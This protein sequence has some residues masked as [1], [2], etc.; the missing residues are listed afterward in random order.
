MGLKVVPQ[1][2][3]GRADIAVTDNYWKDQRWS[4][5]WKDI[6]KGLRKFFEIM[7]GMIET[8]LKGIYCKHDAHK[9]NYNGNIEMLKLWKS[10]L[11]EGYCLFINNHYNSVGLTYYC[12]NKKMSI[13][14]KLWIDMKQNPAWACFFFNAHQ[15]KK[16]TEA[17]SN[18]NK[19]RETPIKERLKWSNSGI[20]WGDHS[21]L[22]KKQRWYKNVLS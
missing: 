11:N 6:I 20:N 4:I 14:G 12:Q 21:I 5:H 1:Q 16:V 9:L 22:R 15:V 10:Y 8:A 19:K 3:E 13:T 7:L 17:N 18:G 2:K